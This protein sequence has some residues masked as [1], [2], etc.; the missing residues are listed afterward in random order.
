M[1][2][3][4]KTLR[5]NKTKTLRNNKTKT[6]R[7]I[8]RYNK[9]KIFNINGVSI[10]YVKTKL[11][12]LRVD[13]YVRTGYYTENI[14]NLG[15]NHLLEHLMVNSYD[16][17]ND[18]CINYFNSLGH[19]ING[20]T[21][22]FF[23]KYVNNNIIDGKSNKES[24]Q[25]II[26]SLLKPKK[27]I[28]K[29]ILLREKNAVIQELKTLLN[30]SNFKF[31]NEQN[32]ILYNNQ[33]LQYIDNMYL[34]L[35]NLKN[36]NIDM[37]YKY[38]NEY[39]SRNN[40]CISIIG[41]ITYESLVNLLKS[42]I[43]KPITSDSYNNMKTFFSPENYPSCI[44]S[45]QLQNR[46]VYYISNNNY[47]STEDDIKN[48][49]NNKNK[50]G[51]SKNVRMEFVFLNKIIYHKS[52]QVYINVILL[53]I[54]R[55]LFYELRTKSKYVYS[56]YTIPVYT[57]NTILIK[58]KT[59]CEPVNAKKVYNKIVILINDLIKNGF[60]VK[61]LQSII[62]ILR[63]SYYRKQY[64][65]NIELNAFYENEIIHHMD[66]DKNNDIMTPYDIRNCIDQCKIEPKGEIYSY[67]C[68]LFNTQVMFYQYDYPI[69][70]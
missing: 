43:P 5:N 59:F 17:C 47:T 14:N 40:I 37:L 50:N 67:L 12:I 51:I 64:K 49:N 36:I 15:I 6:L 68:K 39:Y 69:F 8:K 30:T 34:Q 46:C 24:L 35:K 2:N 38:Y 29:K 55:I 42:V 58:I 57:S 32:K 16:K 62:S 56:I 61:L 66:I 53:Y 65:N 1:V 19:I 63:M 13:G 48:K 44:I 70:D 52:I 27:H 20:H 26:H 22:E 11:D 33:G 3:K 10:F 9:P 18:T 7:N 23:V 60:D 41:N 28:W 31:V 4:T 21:H 25:Y 54:K 45:P